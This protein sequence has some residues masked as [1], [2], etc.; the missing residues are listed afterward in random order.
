MSE[1]FKIGK[2]YKNTIYKTSNVNSNVRS[3]RSASWNPTDFGHWPTELL[4]LTTEAVI[5]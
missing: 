3:V 2:S 5:F 1:S 4:M